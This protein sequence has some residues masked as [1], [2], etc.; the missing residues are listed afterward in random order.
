MKKNASNTLMSR[1][2]KDGKNSFDSS[3]SEY[4][5][6]NQ[7]LNTTFTNDLGDGP[8]AEPFGYSGGIISPVEEGWEVTMVGPEVTMVGPK[9]ASILTFNDIEIQFDSVL[10][11]GIHFRKIREWQR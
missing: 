6:K 11:L 4:S 10:P 2:E 9:E 1:E 7:G 5:I 3:T 8:T